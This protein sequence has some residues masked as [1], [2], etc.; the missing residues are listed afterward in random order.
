MAS[1]DYR[2]SRHTPDKQRDF[3]AAIDLHLAVTSAI[4]RKYKGFDPKPYLYLDLFAGP[5]TDPTGLLGSPRQFLEAAF[6]AQI[7]YVAEFYEVNPDNAQELRESITNDSDHATVFNADHTMV[8]SRHTTV[9]KFQYG[10]VYV[11]PS[12]A[13][14]PFNILSHLGRVYPRLDI[15]INLAF[16]SYKRSVEHPDYVPLDEMLPKLKKVWKIRKPIGKHQW[17]ILIGTNWDSYP[18]LTRFNGD[19]TT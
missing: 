4:F 17:S 13:Q 3:E 7:P 8:V 2:Y 19:S 15:I 1:R 11:D 6:F 16:A 5:G 12:N 10:A 18:V 14:I 9:N